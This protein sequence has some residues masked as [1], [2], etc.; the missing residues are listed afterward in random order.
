MKR[1]IALIQEAQLRLVEAK[2]DED[3][4]IPWKR[5]GGGRSVKPGQQDRR[6]RARPASGTGSS[7]KL[8]DLELLTKLAT[9]R[10]KFEAAQS[11]P[12]MK[13]KVAELEGKYHRSLN[14][15][16]KR[17]LVAPDGART[18]KGVQATK[19]AKLSAENLVRGKSMSLE[20]T[21]KALEARGLSRHGSVA[22]SSRRAGE[23]VIPI[24][25]RKGE[26]VGYAREYREDIYARDG[27]YIVGSRKVGYNVYD[28]DGKEVGYSSN[29]D[30]YGARAL[31]ASKLNERTEA[32]PVAAPQP[33]DTSWDAHVDR[34]RAEQRQKNLEKYGSE[35]PPPVE[36]DRPT[37]RAEQRTRISGAVKTL[38][39]DQAA[40]RLRDH[41]DW[42]TRFEMGGTDF[43]N[44]SMDRLRD[45]ID[46]AQQYGDD[47]VTVK[48]PS[49]SEISL[50]FRQAVEIFE[51]RKRL[52]ATD[53]READLGSV[54]WR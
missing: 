40:Q 32:Q 22:S 34:A 47:R 46:E 50:D 12:A 36:Y 31:L 9:R 10:A 45:A 30:L 29:N 4:W 42:E 53:R 8:D 24:K 16:I 6:K 49:H 52:D 25:T 5:T 41:T 38:P 20:D 43:T 1:R 3:E 48:V 2:K 7:S 21:A 54:P 23:K 13:Y 18:A 15:A 17:G 35:T 51:L 28:L 27:N 14:E 11:D 19:P 26:I 39:A 44:I 37:L 33:V